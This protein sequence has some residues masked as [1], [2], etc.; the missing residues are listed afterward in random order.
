MSE[1]DESGESADPDPGADAGPDP[2]VDADAPERKSPRR[3]F[4][5][6]LRVTRNARIGF[7]VGVGLAVLAYAVRVAEL[8][9]PFQGTQEYPVVG[10]EGWFLV[11]A[12]V[13]ATSTAILVTAALTV[14]R[15]VRLAREADVDADPG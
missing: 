5:E 14:V 9:G 8:L 10:P 6:A 13:L 3:A 7:A 15:A 2:G 4:A 11:L 12:F 1:S